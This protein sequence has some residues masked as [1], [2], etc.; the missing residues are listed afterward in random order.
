MRVL[1]FCESWE[2]G[3]IESFLTSVYES[4]DHRDDEG[5][6]I[7]VDLAACS[8]RPG[9]YDA[10]LAAMGMR[11]REL[12]G[13]TLDYRRN[14]PAFDRLLADGAYDAVHLNLYEG[15]ALAFA[16]R[17]VRAGVPRVIVHSHN[18][19]IRPGRT[20]AA[21]LALH[22]AA[23]RLMPA[24]DPR[25]LRWAP[26][27]AAASFLFGGLGWEL[28]RNGIDAGRFAF[29][30]AA[31]LRVRKE[32][33]LGPGDFAM[34][35]VGRLAA[36]KN[37]AFLI[38]LLAWAREGSGA[39][40]GMPGDPVLLLVGR[41]EDEEPLRRRARERGAGDRVR[42]LGATSDVAPLYQA[43]DVLCVPSLFEGLG[44][45]AVEAQAACLPVVCSPA[46]PP[47]A[48]AGPLLLRS[49]LDPAAWARAI[50]RA[51]SHA[52][53]AEAG[54]K[55]VRAVREAGYDMA[56]VAAGIR[57]AYL[58]APALAGRDHA[59]APAGSTPAPVSAPSGLAPA[60]AAASAPASVA[61][62]APASP[63][64]PGTDDGLVSV[65]VPVYNVAPYLR[66]CVD[67]VLAQIHRDL[68]VVLVNDGST[69]DCPAICDEY[70]AADMRVE[71][72][73]QDNAGLSAA[74]NA[75][76]DRAR[77]AYLAFVDADDAVAPAFVE[78][79]L[80]ACRATGAPLAM[81]GFSTQPQVVVGADDADP[82]DLSRPAP[83]A[84]ATSPAVAAPSS[85]APAC[86]QTIDA[87]EASRRLYL[88]GSTAYAVVWNKLY[89][90]DLL[91][92]ER[93]RFPTG[94]QHEDEFF[95]YRA[96]WA[97][98][99]VCV[100]PR[101]MYSYRQRQDSIMGTGFSARSLDRVVALR[102]REEFYREKGAADLVTL[103]RALRCRAIAGFRE[104]LGSLP[105]D[106]PSELQKD[107]LLSQMR[108]DYR[109]VLL[110]RGP[111]AASL[112]KRLSLTLDVLLRGRR[113]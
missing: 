23:V 87:R 65:I 51:A 69:D 41:G 76:I 88:P 99:A 77:G 20:R 42:F 81:C 21:K 73:H 58:G 82:A 57:R 52:R 84:S 9:P 56:D 34:G 6:P 105:A 95:T 112:K 86:A 17:A 78:E 70:A 18:T 113:G 53:D 25:E 80:S 15:V 110:S 22:R 66:A 24:D 108:S 106:M 83:T 44:I 47:E 107:A 13:S 38:D 90:R 26:S 28:V 85:P 89:R 33:G 12:S 14:L 54:E 91:E 3:G 67:S 29:D 98:G 93:L 109:A 101:R 43:M 5:A 79:L 103:T 2:S 19:D 74:R 46:V 62:S 45:V 92:S 7:R 1:S 4:M 102:E 111:G 55:A 39:S 11:V 94:R 104:H 8:Y 32:L 35:C 100:V 37:Q 16:R 10:R 40:A 36:Q 97:A 27:V 59:S 72:V 31:R 75:G 30:P 96:L 68:Q 71:V 49:E 61:A 64:A 48:A 63:A 50:C 60:S